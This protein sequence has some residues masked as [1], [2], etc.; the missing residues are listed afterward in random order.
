MTTDSEGS[1]R[2]CCEHRRLAL[3]RVRLPRRRFH[4]AI[5]Q[6]PSIPLKKR[7]NVATNGS[8]RENTFEQAL[9]RAVQ[10]SASLTLTSA[11][12]GRRYLM[13]GRCPLS[14]ALCSAVYRASRR[15]NKKSRD[16]ALRPLCLRGRAL[17][18]NPGPLV[19]LSGGEGG[20]VVRKHTP[21]DDV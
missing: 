1:T 20:R 14:A 13:I 7:V 15:R 8:G 6:C 5:G 17:R 4:R 19:D 3:H 2:L 11:L 12:Q 16:Y 9:W 18:R 10:P 21:G